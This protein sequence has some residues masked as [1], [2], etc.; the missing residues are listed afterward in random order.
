M[1]LATYAEV[2]QLPV[3]FLESLGVTENADCLEIPYFNIDGSPFR[4]RLRNSTKRWWGPGEGVLP[5]GLQKLEPGEYCII[6]EGES[7][8]Q[9]FSCHDLRAIGIPGATTFKPEWT[10]Y[11]EAYPIL[12]ICR[13]NDASG[14]QIFVEKVTEGLR[15]GGYTGRI[16]VVRSP[17]GTKDFNDL[18]CQDPD[19]F[20]SAFKKI[21][22]EALDEA[23]EIKEADEDMFSATEMPKP[24]LS[25]I[26]P[27]SG[28][29][30]EYHALM[31]RATDAPSVFHVLVGLGIE[32]KGKKTLQGQQDLIL[33]LPEVNGFQVVMALLAY[34]ESVEPFTISEI[35]QGILVLGATVW[36]L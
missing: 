11:V 24:D 28:W 7:D 36:A 4:S 16:A 31:T 25:R 18:H 13:D 10:K 8:Q 27:E 2:K 3:D 29:L 33:S 23:I 21:E 35:S 14:G 32:V 12:Y 17:Y 34:V 9:T 15:A 19:K 20:K 6:A 1:N 30:S 5:Y 22:A 26:L